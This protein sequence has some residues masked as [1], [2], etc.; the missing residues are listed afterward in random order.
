MTL[1][2]LNHVSIVVSNIE[3]SL[4]FYIEVLG[5]SRHELIDGWLRSESNEVVIHLIEIDDAT[6]PSDDD[7]HHY[8]R[9][10]AFEVNS[11]RQIL[12]SAI[13]YGIT[14]FQMDESGNERACI[15]AD[16]SVDFGLR[17]LFLRDPDGNLFEV[18]EPGFSWP[19][20]FARLEA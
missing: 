20:L 2:R 16:A 10:F 11:I 8:Y 15:N 18:V 17:T 4:I 6:R 14:A 1:R 9:H 12:E 13:R 3:A 5:L 7:L 19:A